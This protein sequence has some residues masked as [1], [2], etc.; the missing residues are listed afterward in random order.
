MFAFTLSPLDLIYPL[1]SLIAWSLRESPTVNQDH[2]Q[3]ILCKNY[4]N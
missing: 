2:M 1:S 3:I 4:A